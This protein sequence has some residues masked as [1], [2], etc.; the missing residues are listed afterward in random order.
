MADKCI[1]QCCSGEK[2]IYIQD[3]SGELLRKIP[4]A[5]KCGHW[6]VLRQLDVE[7]NFLMADRW[8]RHLVIA[9]ANQP[10]PQ[11]DV[12]LL[13]GLSGYVGCGGVVWFRHRLYLASGRYL[14]TFANED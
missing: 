8:I 5:D 14:F 10:S 13:A 1:I 4:I 12:V 2:L 7:G 3:H 9:N 11:W 6:P